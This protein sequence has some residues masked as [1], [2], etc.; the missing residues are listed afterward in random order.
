M[1][2]S[3][4]TLTRRIEALEAR[5]ADVEGGYGQTLYQLHRHAVRTKLDLGKVLTHLGLPAAT[6][7]EIDA[8]IDES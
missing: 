3:L 5:L 8:E 6:D 7:E 1:P 4:Q 2:S